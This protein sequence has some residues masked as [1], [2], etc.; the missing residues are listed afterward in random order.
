MTGDDKDYANPLHSL[1]SE[2]AENEPEEAEEDGDDSGA[3]GR[4]GVDD[5]DEESD[6]SR[7]DGGGGDGE[8]D[9][10]DGDGDTREGHEKD[11]PELDTQIQ[12]IKFNG[13]DLDLELTDE[14]LNDLVQKGYAFQE[15]TRAVAEDKREVAAQAKQLEEAQEE[16]RQFFGDLQK[17]ENIVPQL[18]RMGFPIQQAVEQA[19]LQ[20]IEE[21]QLPEKERLARA[22]KRQ[23][24]ELAEREQRLQER[25]R[26]R[27]EQEE[28][29][30]WQ[31][32]LEKW[33][34][35]ALEDAGLDDSRKWMKLIGVELGPMLS[36]GNPVSYQDIAEAAERVA[37]DWG[38]SKDEPKKELRVKKKN[39]AKPRPKRS[40]TKRRPVTRQDDFI[41]SEDFFDEIRR[42]HG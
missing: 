8:S 4:E 26:A 20:M 6:R 37:E 13:E 28:S 9:E 42:R 18:E 5:R 21:A 22:R 33:V 41:R 25:E 14:E 17:A 39:G 40:G 19:A 15:K 10:D 30:R 11:V 29:D 12:S 2:A 35:K 32:R 27:E 34:P 1:L 24:Q 16:I 38:P 7:D 36:S 31:Q 3:R 23:E